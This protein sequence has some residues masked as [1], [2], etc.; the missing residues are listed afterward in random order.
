[1]ERWNIG[2]FQSHSFSCTKLPES[3]IWPAAQTPELDLQNKTL[4]VSKVWGVICSVQF[5]HSVVSDTLWP[6]NS[7]TPGFPVHHQLPELTQT[8]VHQVGDAIQPSHPLSSHSPPAFNL[9]QHQGLF[10]W[11]SSSYKVSKVLEF[12]LQLGI[13]GRDLKL[14][15]FQKVDLK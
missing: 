11:I 1:M 13:H 9:S 2:I 7:S 12:Q 6:I 10:Q 5:I 3:S 4:K 14:Y 15:T 8:H